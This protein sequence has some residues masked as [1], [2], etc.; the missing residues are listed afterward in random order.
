MDTEVRIESASVVCPNCHTAQ[1]IA[2]ADLQQARCDACGRLLFTGEPVSLEADAFD[3]HLS[4]FEL[5]LVVDFWA[6]W[7]ARCRMMAP[8]FAQAAE[9]LEPEYRLVKVD[10]DETPELALRFGVRSIASIAIFARGRETAAFPV[11]S[12]PVVWSSSCAR[13]RRSGQR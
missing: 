13:M 4:A 11:C 10:T 7:C 3:R 9:A 2:R 5:P 6:P 8:V 1:R 12:T